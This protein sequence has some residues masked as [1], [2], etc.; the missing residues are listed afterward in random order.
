MDGTVDSMDSTAGRVA[1]GLG[2]AIVVSVL[3]LAI[4]FVAGEPFGQ[5]NDAGNAV[6][7]ILSAALAILLA[8][9]AAG[10]AGVVAAVVGAVITATGSWLVV[11]GTTG[12]L[13]A[14]FV[15]TIGF[16]LIGVWLALVAWS[17]VAGGWSR[18]L[19]SVARSAAVA[20]VIGGA[21][22]VPGALLGLDEFDAVPPWLWP[23]ALGWLGTYL[24]YPAWAIW[25]GVRR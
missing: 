22:A 7:G 9:R 2:A 25:F 20:M 15:S 8:S 4:F 17:P 19:R 24:L 14:G 18:G 12:F 23:Y 21:A 13:L 6:V 16:G 3:S 11:S 10:T 1:I 5:I